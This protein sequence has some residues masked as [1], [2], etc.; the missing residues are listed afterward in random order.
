MYFPPPGSLARF[1]I[2]ALVMVTVW[3]AGV[4]S[5]SSYYAKQLASVPTAVQ[6]WEQDTPFLEW[7]IFPY[8][9]SSYLFARAFFWCRTKEQVRT[10]RNRMLFVVAVAGLC[11]LIFPLRHAFVKP[12][13]VGFP[14]QPLFWLLHH[15]D[16]PYNQAPSLHVTFCVL[17]AAAARWRFDGFRLYLIWSALA[18]IAC[19]T[20]FVYQHH[21]VDVLTGLLLG[22][23]ALV[24][25]PLKE[26]YLTMPS[27]PSGQVTS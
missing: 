25:L 4:Y 8:F 10:L 23:L 7:M 14:F 17:H 27:Q 18:L 16:S 15:A 1:R 6:S 2:F 26:N 5:F 22:T 20:V 19:S 13:G 3:F 9:G 11:F 24:L 12:A 21:A